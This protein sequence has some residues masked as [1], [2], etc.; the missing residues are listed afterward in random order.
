MMSNES[1]PIIEPGFILAVKLTAGTTSVL[2]ILGASLIIITYVVF[3]NLRTTARQLL[4]SISIA[5]IIVSL[6]HLVGLI[7]NF[8]RFIYQFNNE[9][10]NTSTSDPLCISQAAFSM[11]GTL[12]SFLLS[13]AIGVYLVGLVVW[14]KP[15]VW[16]K[17]VPVIYIICW[18]IPSIMVIPNAVVHSFGF[19]LGANI[20]ELASTGKTRD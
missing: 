12:A 6:S 5:D 15:H 8:E 10:W 16:K 13:L 9:T 14:K 1:F 17:T 18:G 11:F 20:G 7:A 19:A 2:S 3:P 4:I